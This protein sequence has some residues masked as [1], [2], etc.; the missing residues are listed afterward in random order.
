VK[1]PAIA[2]LAGLFLSFP[3]AAN[4]PAPR[5]CG[6]PAK[7]CAGF[8]E[9]DLSFPLP[10]DA[11]AR[12]HA[13][14]TQ[15]YA[16]M[17]LTAERCLITENRRKEVQAQF[18]GRKVFAMRFQCDEKVENNVTYSNVNDKLA[19]LA[20]YAGE[21]REAAEALLGQARKMGKF[22]GANLRRIHVVY[23]YP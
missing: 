12:T 23:V 4:E 7:P 19:F 18:P 9:H 15:F 6:D 14:S 13:Q 5:P 17:L 3:A 1:T 22:A 8:K 10:T 21:G 16:V 11:V 20:V 2:F